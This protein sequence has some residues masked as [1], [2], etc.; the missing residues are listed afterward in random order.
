MADQKSM[1]CVGG[2]RAGQRY[3]VLYGSGFRVPIKPD[4]P[5]NDPQSPEWQ[6]NKPVKVEFADYR[7]ET[8]HT[9]QGDTS[10][11]VPQGQTPLETITMLL[12]AYEQQH[13]IMEA[14][15]ERAEQACRYALK[16]QNFDSDTHPEYRSG[17]EVAA[18]VCEG[19]I[20]PQVMRHIEHDLSQG[21]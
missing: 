5:E 16:H 4:V 15:I 17:W 9:P 1:L 19:A 13:K 7:E 2:P 11:W 3:A 20:R 18:H 8:F 12:E 10:F 6:P 14:V 21:E